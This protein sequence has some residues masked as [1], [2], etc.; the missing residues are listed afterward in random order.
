MINY[1]FGFLALLSLLS[2][3]SMTYSLGGIHRTF[4]SLT[5]GIVENAVYPLVQENGQFLLYYD[6]QVLKDDVEQYLAKELSPY[7]DSFRLG[8]FYFEVSTKTPCQ[9]QCDGVQIRLIVEI[10]ALLTY[11]DELRFELHARET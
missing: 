11:D 1:F 8:F 3:F 6:S 9:L 7:T 5:R 4:L 10:N 2:T